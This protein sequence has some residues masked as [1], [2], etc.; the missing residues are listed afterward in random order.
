MQATDLYS[1][2]PIL[3]GLG[4]TLEKE[5]PH[6]SGERFL[7]SPHK[8]VLVGTMGGNRVVIKTSNEPEGK[9]ELKHER[10]ARETLNKLPFAHHTFFVPKELLFVERDNY[11]IAITAFIAQGKAFIAY[12]LEEQFFLALKAFEEQEGVHATTSSHAN[13]IRDVF[14]MY[15]AQDYLNDFEVFKNDITEYMRDTGELKNL[16][17]EALQFLRA[18]KTLIERYSGFLTHTDF[19]PH[20]LRIVDGSLYL[21]DHTSIHFG[22]KY[23]S[24][25]RFLNFMAVHNPALEKKLAQYVQENRG[26]EEYLSLRLMRV[27]KAG[28]LL[29][30]HSQNLS[31]TTGDLHMLTQARIT[32]WTEALRSLLADTGIPPIRVGEYVRARNKLRTEEETRRQKEIGHL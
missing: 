28:F 14:G 5:Q 9:S 29:R 16:L 22:N 32:F 1:L 2:T 8:L 18:N 30:F 12:P 21:L 27:Y 17:E 24:W 13:L 15:D 7:L 3:E 23:E 10:R 6:I 20:N 26:E 31:K 25:G 4:I 11:V 19:A